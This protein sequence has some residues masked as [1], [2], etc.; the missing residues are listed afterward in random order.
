MY[1]HRKFDIH[2]YILP[3]CYNPCKDL[4]LLNMLYGEIKIIIII[5][6]NESIVIGNGTKL[7][8]LTILQ[9]RQTNL[10]KQRKY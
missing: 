5:I 10:L 8:V 3:I 1:K 9:I 6:M 7:S 4:F 2:E